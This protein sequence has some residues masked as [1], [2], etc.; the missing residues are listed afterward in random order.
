M[1][2]DATGAGAAPRA[3]ESTPAP[4][5]Q[6]PVTRAPESVT[7]M[8]PSPD[9]RHRES[10]SRARVRRRVGASRHTSRGQRP[11]PLS[12]VVKSARRLEGRTRQGFRDLLISYLIHSHVAVVQAGCHQ[13]RAREL[14]R[15][16]RCRRCFGRGTF[17]PTASRR[18]RAMPPRN[19]RVS[20]SQAPG[21][22][23]AVVS[24]GAKSARSRKAA[25]NGRP[26][27]TALS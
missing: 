17:L 18:G 15:P 7:R 12:T 6:R 22:S 25:V 11:P 2:D 14:A 27:R 20:A 26:P 19:A 8:E 1:P 13:C 9:A 23:G 10:P 24:E 4:A 16:R 21:A 5:P 3:A